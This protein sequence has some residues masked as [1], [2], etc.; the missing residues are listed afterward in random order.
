MM[1]IDSTQVI[2]ETRVKYAYTIS[3]RIRRVKGKTRISY[4]FSLMDI[5]SKK[6]ILQFT[7]KD[8]YPLIEY[9]SMDERYIQGRDYEITKKERNTKTGKLNIAEVRFYNPECARRATV[10]MLSIIGVENN[11]LW[12]SKMTRVVKKLGLSA[13]DF[14]FNTAID[15]YIL[16][17]TGFERRI[18]ILRVGKAIRVLYEKQIR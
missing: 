17:K 12:I 8:W 7:T 13:V 2:T 11:T 3:V 15:R 18:S 10:F 6:P 5:V 14:W 9:L 4:R 16:S 1:P